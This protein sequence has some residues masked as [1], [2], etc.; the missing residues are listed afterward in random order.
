MFSQKSSPPSV[1]AM[2]ERIFKNISRVHNYL[3]I[4]ESEINDPRKLGPGAADEEWLE[5]TRALRDSLDE[6]EK[7]LKSRDWTSAN[8]S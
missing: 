7:F 2:G 4:L 5:A 6:L 3:D 1:Q 8:E